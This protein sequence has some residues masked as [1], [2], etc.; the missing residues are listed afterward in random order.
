MK[1]LLTFFVNINIFAVDISYKSNKLKKQLTKAKEMQ[2][3]FG[4]MAKK[5]NQRIKEIKASENLCDLMKIPAA[6]CHELHGD[7]K[8]QYAVSI[9]GN[10]RLIFEPN[11]DPIPLKDDNSID[12]VKVTAIEMLKKEDYH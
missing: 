7:R 1:L 11:H 5:V 4:M 9:S 2:K 3:E 8:G 12:T 6:K 10:Y